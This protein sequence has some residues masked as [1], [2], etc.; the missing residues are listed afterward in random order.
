MHWFLRVW[1]GLFFPPAC[2]SFCIQMLKIKC[3]GY[4]YV[5]VISPSQ[6]E[7]YPKASLLGLP[8]WGKL[9]PLNSRGFLHD[10]KY[11]DV[12]LVMSQYL[13]STLCAK[14][15]FSRRPWKGFS[16]S[17]PSVRAG[18]FSTAA[19]RHEPVKG[20]RSKGGK[21]EV[22]KKC[23]QIQR[24]LLPAPPNCLRGYTEPCSHSWISCY[25]FC[26]EQA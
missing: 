15:K 21:S 3:V 13:S 11:Q 18:M 1:G 12:Q 2:L 17:G 19:L 26:W 8:R 22:Q 25:G 7:I 16:G 5:G 20:W 10:Q 24:V 9:I 14:A 23:L 6:T 4:E